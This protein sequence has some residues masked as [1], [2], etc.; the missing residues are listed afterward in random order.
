[1]INN[2]PN[3]KGK[4][5]FKRISIKEA[6]TLNER[7]TIKE[8]VNKAKEENAKEPSDTKYIWRVRGSPKTV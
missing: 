3:L 8:F 4:P 6:L 5:D 1:M 7:M 2:L